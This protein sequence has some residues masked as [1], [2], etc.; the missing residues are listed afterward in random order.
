MMKYIKRHLWLKVFAAVL[1]IIP[2]QGFGQQTA[3]GPLVDTILVCLENHDAV[4]MVKHMNNPVDIKIDEKKGIYSLSQAKLLMKDFFHNHPF[5]SVTKN[6]TS[7]SGKNEVS[8]IG[9]YQSEGSTFRLYFLLKR[10]E[11]TFKI[12][13]FYIEK[14]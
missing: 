9:T 14:S 4:T 7:H 2:S 1:F 8:V 11:E 3:S 6:H 13:Q 5:T 12:Y 10:K